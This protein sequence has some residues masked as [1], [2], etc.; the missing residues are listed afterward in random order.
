MSGSCVFSGATSTSDHGVQHCH[1]HSACSDLTV[2]FESLKLGHFSFRVLEL[3]ACFHWN[4]NI[5]LPR[6]LNFK[7]YVTKKI[8]S[9][10]GIS[11]RFLAQLV[12]K[13]GG[14]VCVLDEHITSWDWSGPL[15]LISSNRWSSRNTLYSM[16]DYFLVLEF[17]AQQAQDVNG[18]AQ[19]KGLRRIT[20]EGKPNCRAVGSG[21]TDCRIRPRGKQ[22]KP[23]SRHVGS[24]NC[25]LLLSADVEGSW[26]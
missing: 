16:R 4:T 5:G 21:F 24:G 25:C 26:F 23:R 12:A 10:I 2:G 18:D 7:L 17:I 6:A 11:H 19:L 8:W 13:D 14:D 20:N 9:D 1:L 22:V 15:R 3:A